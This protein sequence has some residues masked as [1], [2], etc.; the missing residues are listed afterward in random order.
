[1]VDDPLGRVTFGWRSVRLFPQVQKSFDRD[2]RG[3]TSLRVAPV[4]IKQTANF[5]V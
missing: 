5:G 3:F 1:L 4:L 2:Q